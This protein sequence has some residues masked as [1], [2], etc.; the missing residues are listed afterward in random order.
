MNVLWR[1]PD[2]RSGPFCAP[3]GSWCDGRPKLLFDHL[4]K[5]HHPKVAAYAANLGLDITI[6]AWRLVDAARMPPMPAAIERVDSGEAI[7][8]E[9][10][11]ERLA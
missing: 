1:N 5:A 7:I 3:A 6:A 11:G 8:R 9:A 10:E 2:V 4:L